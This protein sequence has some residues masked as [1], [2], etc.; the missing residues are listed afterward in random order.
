VSI[1]LL[2]NIITAFLWM[3]FS[4]SWTIVDFLTG[5]LVG[6]ALIFLMRRYFPRP[7]YPIKV[8]ALC[9]FVYVAIREILS[10][11]IFVLRFVLKPKMDFEPGIFALNTRL[12]G[13]IE[14]TMLSLL[15]TLT[16]GSVVLEVSPDGKVLYIH[17]MDLVDVKNTVIKT[18]YALE[19]A[20]MEVTRN[21]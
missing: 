1:Q 8:W 16:P 9:K 6:L 3:L 19:E 14:I 20:I 2:V 10:S 7:F 12:R 18:I 13:A 4:E 17:A 15:I 11:A 21:A 5:Y